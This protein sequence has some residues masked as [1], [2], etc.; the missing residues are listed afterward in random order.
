M[1]PASK[2]MVARLF[3]QPAMLVQESDPL[4]FDSREASRWL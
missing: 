3:R 1:I 2:P 4:T